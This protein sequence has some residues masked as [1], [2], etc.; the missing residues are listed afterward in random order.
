MAEELP[1]SDIPGLPGP[2]LD[3]K[4]GDYIIVYDTTEGVTKKSPV[5]IFFPAGPST[6]YKWVSNF[7]YDEDAIVEHEG[8][9]WISLHDNNLGNIPTEGA[10]WSE[11]VKSSSGL[12]LYTPG[13]FT[14]DPAI[15]LSDHEGGNLALYWLANP[16]RP[17][18]STDIAAEQ[19][20]GDWKLLTERFTADINV[21][22]A[23][24]KTLGKYGNGQVIPANGKTPKEVILDLAIEYLTPTFSA[25][26]ITG[27]ATTVELGT[28]IAAGMKAFTWA[29]TNN[30][31]IQANT[32]AVRDQTA[33]ADLAVALAN[34]GAENINFPAPVTLVNE[35]DTQVFR[36]RATNTQA[37]QFTR[38]LTIIA[39]YVR[40]YGVGSQPAN[41]ADVRALDGETFGNTFSIEIPA[42][43]TEIAFAYEA[44]RPDIV[45]SSVKYVEGFNSNVGNTF[46]KFT[47]NVNDA[48]GTPRSYKVYIAVLGGPYPSDA[49]Y[50]VT[51]P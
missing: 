8:K 11:V 26:A 10:D 2:Y 1:N 7:N 12:V 48:A 22:L 4:I 15:V 14:Q 13:I 39:D 50:N 38:D 47:F 20:A 5:E 41:S 25:F 17:Y 23:G 28:T 21:V 35:G 43:E 30:G 29:T 36:I 51:I 42:G 31:N 45:D 49:T 24:G 6:N 27:Q 16:T 44:T 18:N 37:V 33:G 32:V 34:D 46:T 3:P 9:W 19:I 40:F